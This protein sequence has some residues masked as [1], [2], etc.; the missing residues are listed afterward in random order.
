MPPRTEPNWL[1][2]KKVFERLEDAV[3]WFGRGETADGAEAD[4]PSPYCVLY[5]WDLPDGGNPDAGIDA[6]ESAGAG[7]VWDHGSN[8]CWHGALRVLCSVAGRPHLGAP[9]R[10]EY[11]WPKPV[12]CVGVCQHPQAL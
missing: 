3:T 5:S 2:N 10:I 8:N 6:H 7:D 9:D 4:P 1:P 12:G 11:P